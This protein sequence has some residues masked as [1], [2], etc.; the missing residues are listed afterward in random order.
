MLKPSQFR[1][2]RLLSGLRR[3]VEINPHH[4]AVNGGERQRVAKF[5]RFDIVTVIF[6]AR[7]RAGWG[8]SYLPVVSG[9]LTLYFTHY[10]STH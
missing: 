1:S 3:L 9:H 10:D 2:V 8:I 6:I 7:G 4:G 5:S